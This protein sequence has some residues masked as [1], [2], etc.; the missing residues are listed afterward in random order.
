MESDA[1]EIMGEVDAI[2]GVME[3]YPVADIPDE[4]LDDGIMRMEGLGNDVTTLL[5]QNRGLVRKYHA[6][7]HQPLSH[8]L[9]RRSIKTFYLE[10]SRNT[11]ESACVT[12]TAF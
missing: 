8:P 10:E 7:S 4:F 3:G 12:C 9:G 11:W 5:K 1:E 2:M 6:T